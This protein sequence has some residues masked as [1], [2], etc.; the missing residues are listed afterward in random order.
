MTGAVEEERG[1]DA[2]VYVLW[3]KKQPTNFQHAAELSVKM[4]LR[5]K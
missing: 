3:V 5:Q 1:Y 2:S 4:G